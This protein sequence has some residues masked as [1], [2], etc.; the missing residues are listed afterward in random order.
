[1]HD[2]GS[3]GAVHSGSGNDGHDAGDT[4]DH[5]GV[6]EGSGC[7]LGEEGHQEGAEERS[8]GV[9]IT[10]FYSCQINDP[11]GGADESGGDQMAAG[12]VEDQGVAYGGE[13]ACE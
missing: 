1:M 6:F 4:E 2:E 9:S 10:G 8:H 7:D 5:N 12:L 11:A 3:H 13:E